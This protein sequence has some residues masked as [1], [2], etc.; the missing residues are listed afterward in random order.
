M[1]ESKVAPTDGSKIHDKYHDPDDPAYD[2]RVDPDVGPYDPD[3]DYFP[4]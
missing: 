3:N 1:T 4:E 2:P